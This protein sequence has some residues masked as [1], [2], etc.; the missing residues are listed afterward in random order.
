MCE[1]FNYE[2]KQ[3]ERTRIMNVSLKGLTVGDW[4]DLS[5][6]ELNTI[7]S[8]TDESSSEM[9]VPKKAKSSH[10][11]NFKSQS[12]SAAIEKNTPSNIVKPNRKEQLK[13]LINRKKP[14]AQ[15]T[16]KRTST[17]VKGQ[18]KNASKITPKPARNKSTV[19]KKQRNR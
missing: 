13:N 15:S 3:L 7:V 18:Y 9:Q 12:L 19:S 1:Y 16:K 6:Q 14:A 11:S 5:P 4:R 10:K 8:L 17:S 2:V